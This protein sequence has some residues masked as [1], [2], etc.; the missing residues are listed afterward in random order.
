LADDQRASICGI[1]EPV[2]AAILVS[3]AFD[4]TPGSRGRRLT[5]Q[6]LRSL[7]RSAFAGWDTLP[8]SLQTDNEA[9][10]GGHLS[11]PMPSQLSLWLIGLGKEKYRCERP[12]VGHRVSF[13]R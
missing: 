9:C 2:G 1:G 12:H 8:D 13:V 5:W 3:Q 4:L 6:E 11:D 10:L 7:I